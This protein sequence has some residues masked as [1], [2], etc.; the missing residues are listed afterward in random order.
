M[1]PLTELLAS[2]DGRSFLESRDVSFEATVFTGRLR[3]PADGGLT[4]LFGL[5]A[6]ARPVY[7]AHQIHVDFRRSVVS[8]F[9]AALHLGGASVEPVMLWLDTDRA[10]SDRA[11]TTITWPLPEGEASMRLVPQRFRNLEPRF[12]PVERGRLEEVV[13]RL[14][15]W[16]DRTV[17]DPARRDDANARLER[18]AAALLHDEPTTLARS[19]LASASCLLLE[20]LK[21]G[22][23]SSFVSTLA[24]RGLLSQALNDVLSVIDDIVLVFNG[25]VE[26][27]IASDVDPQVHALPDDYLPLYYACDACGARRR[28]GHARKGTDHFAVM[29][30]SCGASHRF[31]L[32]DRGLSLGELEATERWSADV[33][34]PLYVNDLASGVVAGRSSALYGLVLNDVVAKVL[35]RSPIPM[36]VP[37]D[38]VELS[39]DAGSVDS[40]LYEYLVGA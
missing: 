29:T 18:L 7:V 22:P 28:L 12:V 16:L 37:E 13:T 21:F 30:C 15:M 14:R 40:L 17:A 25:S 19:N 10:G 2:A 11:S 34:L 38:L 9:R 24:S 33:T 27:L 26:E 6:G 23:P 1:R 32:G 4:D 39:A 5:P 3:P 20:H 35:G 36:L 8:K 31:H